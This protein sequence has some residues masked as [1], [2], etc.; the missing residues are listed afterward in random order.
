MPAVHLTQEQFVEANELIFRT[1]EL[2]AEMR[3]S[4]SDRERF[5]AAR[6]EWKQKT[7]RL[8]SILPPVTEPLD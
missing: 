6:H 3:I 5:L 2:L 7:D 4:F 1:R 8:N